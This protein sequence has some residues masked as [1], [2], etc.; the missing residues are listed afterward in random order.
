MKLTVELSK[1][2][3]GFFGSF[4][5]ETNNCILDGYRISDR[6]LE[7]VI[8]NAELT[9]PNT[10]IITLKDKEF[11]GI[12]SEVNAQDF[13]EHVAN[14]FV[15][16]GGRSSTTRCMGLPEKDEEEHG[17]YNYFLG[18]EKNVCPK[19]YH[20]DCDTF[21]LEKTGFRSYDGEITK[22]NWEE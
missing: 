1:P 9:S 15:E 11:E 7:G 16:S 8:F 22:F 17:H 4:H 18:M 5:G 21:L 14:H 20:Y 3:K 2:A 19:E 6:F 12:M 13:F 10:L